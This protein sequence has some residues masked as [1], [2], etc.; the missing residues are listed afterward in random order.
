VAFGELPDH[1]QDDE[2][3]LA[4]DMK[5]LL[6]LMRADENED[7]LPY[8]CRF[9]ATRQGWPVTQHKRASRILGRLD[10]WDV[11]KCVGVETRIT[12]FGRAVKLYDAPK[13]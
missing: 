11:V 6:G 9:A 4:A 13:D 12:K 3:A 7:P 5:L 2:R 8:S 1:A 10:R